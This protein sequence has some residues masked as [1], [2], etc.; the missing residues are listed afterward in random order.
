ME[1]QND[2]LIF[3]GIS[4]IADLDGYLVQ[5]T[6]SRLLKGVREICLRTDK[7]NGWLERKFLLIRAYFS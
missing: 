7:G 5:S 1:K 3:K 2:T 6:I 4:K